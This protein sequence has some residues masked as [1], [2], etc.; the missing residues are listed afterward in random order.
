[1]EP[2][3]ATNNVRSQTQLTC[4]NKKRRVLWRVFPDVDVPRRQGLGPES[5]RSA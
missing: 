5:W 4:V 2:P 3:A 1:M